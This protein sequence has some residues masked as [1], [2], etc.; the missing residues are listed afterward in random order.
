[1]Q[2]TTSTVQRLHYCM[3]LYSCSF[4]GVNV[5]VP[6]WDRSSSQ[7]DVT[8]QDSQCLDVWMFWEKC[9]VKEAVLVSHWKTL[10]CFSVFEAC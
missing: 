10:G 5:V 8:T 4:Y 7:T 9:K 6:V 2:R 1:M 3:Q